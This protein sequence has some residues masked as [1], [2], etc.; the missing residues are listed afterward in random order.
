MGCGSSRAADASAYAVDA[1]PG[2]AES[3]SAGQQTRGFSRVDDAYPYSEVPHPGTPTVEPRR[4]GSSC[5]GDEEPPCAS[6]DRD[7]SPGDDR[8]PRSSRWRT[9][10]FAATHPLASAA[11]ASPRSLRRAGPARRAEWIPRVSLGARETADENDAATDFADLAESG[12]VKSVDEGSDASEPAERSSGETTEETPFSNGEED[13]KERASR[14]CSRRV[15]RSRGRATDTFETD[16]KTSPLTAAAA[17]AD[18]D[19]AEKNHRDVVAAAVE[20]VREAVAAVRRAA[21]P[22]VPEIRDD[23][24]VSD[25]RASRIS[26]VPALELREFVPGVGT[27]TRRRTNAAIVARTAM[28]LYR[29]TKHENERNRLY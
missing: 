7:E 9:P 24:R 18:D 23:P 28:E 26:E 11:A 20:A 8:P 2:D 14:D 6:P 3:P 25:L 17:A 22:L 10:A 1:G 21:V 29:R 12:T 19:D 13:S 27:T 5:A 16:E 15:S 4:S